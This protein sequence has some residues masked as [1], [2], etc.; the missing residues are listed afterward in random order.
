[1]TGTTLMGLYEFVHLNKH[2]SR[3]SVSA[4]VTET[5]SG[6]LL[7]KHFLNFCTF[8][9]ENIQDVQQA[10]YV[11]LA[12]LVILCLTEDNDACLILHDKDSGC[13]IPSIHEVS[14]TLDL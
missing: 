9:V 10:Y 13:I 2:F 7:M 14:T 4:L 12:F 3:T 11:K 8:I 6:P 1:M 5:D